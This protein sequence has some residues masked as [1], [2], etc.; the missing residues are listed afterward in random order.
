MSYR[1]YLVEIKKDDFVKLK[2]YQ[3]KDKNS[4]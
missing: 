1:D 2:Q 4:N 3:E